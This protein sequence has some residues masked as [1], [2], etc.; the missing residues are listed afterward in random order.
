MVV[1]MKELYWDE[2]DRSRAVHMLNEEDISRFRRLESVPVCHSISSWLFGQCIL[3]TVL[4]F[5]NRDG[6]PVRI[7]SGV[8]GKV[9]EE[10]SYGV[11]LCGDFIFDV[12][13]SDNLIKTVSPLMNL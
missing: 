1:Q 6:S 2:E 11:V 10:H 7:K 4:A 5:R 8:S 9:E 12:K 13:Y 3:N